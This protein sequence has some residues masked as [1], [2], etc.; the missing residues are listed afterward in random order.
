VLTLL[1]SGLRAGE[2]VSLRIGDVDTRPGL[3]TVMGKGRKARQVRVGAKARGAIV[4][5]LGR[6]RMGHLD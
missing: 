6:R 4:R 3:C 2:L 5:M 1:D